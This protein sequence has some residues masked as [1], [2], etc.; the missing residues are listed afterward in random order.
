MMDNPGAQRPAASQPPLLRLVAALR[1]PDF[2][3]L[4]ASTVSNQ[5]G[6]GMQQVLLGWLVFEMTGSRIA[7]LANGVVLA[8]GVLVMGV[9]LTR[10]RRIEAVGVQG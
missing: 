10:L 8:A 3:V 2:R 5:L 4:W 6:Q 9:V 1:Y 7:L